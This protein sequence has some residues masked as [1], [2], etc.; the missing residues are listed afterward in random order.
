MSEIDIKHNQVPTRENRLGAIT[1]YVGTIGELNSQA[2]GC[3]V[4]NRERCFSQASACASGCCQGQLS[5]IQNV[6]VINHGAIGCAADAVATNV[7][8]KSGA[9]IRGLEYS[10]VRIVSSNLLERD[11]VFGAVD[12]LK[13]T[14]LQAAKRYH[15]DAIF[16]TTSCV[17]GIIGEDIQ[18]ALEDLKPQLDIP[19]VPAF[20]EGFRSKVW[21]S[22]FDSAFHAVLFGIVEPPRQVEKTNKVNFVNFRGSARN[23]IIRTFKKLGVEP[24]F[25]LQYATIEELKRLSEA[26]ATV[27]ICGTLGSYIGNGLEQN[28]G[29]PYIKTEQPH[30]IQ[31]YINWMRNLGTFLGKE[32]EVEEHLA[33]EE[34]RTR[35]ELAELRAKLKGKRVVVGMGPSFGHNYTRVLEELGLDVVWTATWHFDQNYDHGDVPESTKRLAEID[36]SLKVSVG[37]QQNY[38]IVNLLNK[39]QPD[40][41][42][43]RHGG[44]SVWATKMGIATHMVVDEFTAFGY[45]GIVNFGNILVDKLTNRALAKRLASRIQLPYSEW[46]LGQDSFSFLQEEVF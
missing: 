37:D 10:N 36:D 14:I 38:E 26:R 41:Y 2:G 35:E 11:T 7:N 29:V 34:E 28:Y 3:G 8:K 16:V 23:E 15:P 4:Q 30:G 21:A 32:K 5:S 9:R 6:V 45:N 31:G 13:D 20:C 17:S 25:L 44:S 12:K 40:L 33:E 1:G 18:G 22:G 24:V 42:V 43:T 27:S 46:W 39:L 19:L